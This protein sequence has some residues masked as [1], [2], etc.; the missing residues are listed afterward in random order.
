MKW[1]DLLEL[2]FRS[3]FLRVTH[4]PV[5]QTVLD[6]SPFGHAFVRNFARSLHAFGRFFVGTYGLFGSASFDRS[7]C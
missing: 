3:A 2:A 5:D 1:A 4:R 7:Q 6:L